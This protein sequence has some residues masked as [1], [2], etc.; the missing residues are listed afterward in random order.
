MKP[1]V[2]LWKD[3]GSY[4]LLWFTQLISGLGSAMTAYALVIWSY[5]QAGSA[6]RTALLMV[7]SYAPY[8]ICSIFAGALSDRWDK[9]KTMLICDALAALSTF[10]VLLLLRQNALRIWHLYI[11][12]AV[13]GLMNTFQQPASEVATTALLKREYYQK[14]GGLRYLSNAVNSILTPIITTAVMGLWG[15]ETVIALDLG[16]FVI[17]FFVLLFL[18]PIPGTEVKKQKESVL[19]SAA[20][21]CRWLKANPGIFHLMLFLAG[22]NLVASMF[23][24][25]L[26]AMILSKASETA[27]GTVNAVTGIS[28]LVGSIL[29]SLLPA[30]RS[31]VRAIRFC[32]MLSMC[33]ENFF[34]AFGDSVWAWCLGAILGWITLPWM[35]A[36]LE[37][38]NRLNIP[39]EIQGR[40]FAARNSFQFF[41]IPVG[42]FLGGIL[43]DN[44]F[45]PLMSG[46]TADGLLVRL[47]GSGKGSGA[48]FLFAV[49]WLAGI[50]V[51][52]IFRAD[53]HIRELEAP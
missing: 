6:L 22:I 40:V 44:V 15:I 25:A 53:K 37:A 20:E 52:L 1:L 45:E 30:P 17:A 18:I 33:T 39:M 50:G 38:I 46:Q 35:S 13:S 49:L 32:L 51:C 41:T 4:L 2:K 11:V 29:A 34:L 19:R 43:V 12:N 24:A 21:G 28:M 26:P 23:N 36:N 5:T 9:K 31:R 3:M 48:A 47:F 14:V 7:C 8:V 10:T 27:L 42:Y 16:S